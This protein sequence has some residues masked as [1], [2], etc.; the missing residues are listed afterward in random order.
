M[1]QGRARPLKTPSI[2]TLGSRAAHGAGKQGVQADS[3]SLKTHT[4]KRAMHTVPEV[5]T[6]ALQQGLLFGVLRARP[7]WERCSW[8]GLHNLPTSTRQGVS[9]AALAL[10]AGH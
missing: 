8:C 1:G 6:P 10:L 3:T 5:A 4:Q 7:M 2:T 9:A